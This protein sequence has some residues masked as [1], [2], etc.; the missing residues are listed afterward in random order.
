ML[1]DE[2]TA[3]HL[4]ENLGIE[5]I[6]ASVERC[7]LEVKRIVFER[8]SFVVMQLMVEKV[9]PAEMESFLYDL[10][11]HHDQIWHVHKNRHP[12]VCIREST[13]RSTSGS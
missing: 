6:V 7:Y 8:I 1:F 4:W 2:S 11:P 5:V 12:A 3:E 9:L 10:S 13:R